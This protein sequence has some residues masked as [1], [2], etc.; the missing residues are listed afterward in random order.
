MISKVINGIS[1]SCFI[2][3]FTLLNAANSCFGNDLL[4]KQA[5]IDQQKI[6]AYL[7]EHKLTTQ[8]TPS[9]LHYYVYEKGTGEKPSPYAVATVNYTANFLNGTQFYNTY[10][11]DLPEKFQLNLTIKGWMEGLPLLNKGSKA[12]LI[13]PS[14]LAYGAAGKGK[15]IL[16]NS[17]LVFDVHLMDFYDVQLS[18]DA[19]AIETYIKTN[20][21]EMEHTNSGVYYKIEK[22]GDGW[23]AA[24]YNTVVLDYH[25]TL[26]N[27]S[28]FWSTYEGGQPLKIKLNESLKA[29]YE[30]IPMLREGGKVKIIAPPSM[31]Y[32]EKGS[33]P[34]ISPNAILVY[35]LELIDVQ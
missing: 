14:H 31:A 19:A 17:V 22:L 12:I 18:K 35:D 8:V 25:G 30:I 13:I 23:G 34:Y 2:F 20:N 3:F 1:F 11:Y 5:A 10:K 33:P 9:G 6:E 4:R 21:L 28:T 26:L 7:I 29:F 32:G 15:E 16:P 27:G 24:S